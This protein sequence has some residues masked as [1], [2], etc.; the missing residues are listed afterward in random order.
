V[1][2]PADVA[3]AK[4][5]IAAQGLAVSPT[6]QALLDFFPLSP[7]NTLIAQTPTTAKMDEFVIKID[8]RVN[9]SNT[10]SGR[11]ILG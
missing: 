1:P 2:S 6:G 3:G 4:A 7:S 9:R 10:I 8:H 5:D 11:Y